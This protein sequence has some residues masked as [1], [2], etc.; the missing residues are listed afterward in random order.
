M[1]VRMNDNL[2]REKVLPDSENMILAFVSLQKEEALTFHDA[3]SPK[4]VSGVHDITFPESQSKD[5]KQSGD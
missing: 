2:Q 4:S 1:V 5:C 3:L